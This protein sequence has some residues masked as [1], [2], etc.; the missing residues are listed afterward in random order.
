VFIGLTTITLRPLVQLPDP[1]PSSPAGAV[2]GPVPT[3]RA[4]TLCFEVLVPYLDPQESFVK[5]LPAD[6]RHTL[7]FK[8]WALDV[9]RAVAC[10]RE[11]FREHRFRHRTARIVPEGPVALR[12]VRPE[13]DEVL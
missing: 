13:G 9:T 11:R 8:V 4:P 10:A 3:G 7:V 6:A 5:Q 12:V 2:P 1:K